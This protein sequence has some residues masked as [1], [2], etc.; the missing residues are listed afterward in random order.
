MVQYIVLVVIMITRLF[1][2]L[3]PLI[4]F[5]YVYFIFNFQ[6]IYK[7][8]NNRNYNLHTNLGITNNN[9]NSALLRSHFPN[10]QTVTHAASNHHAN[11]IPA[12]NWRRHFFGG[13][14]SPPP[15]PS[16]SQTTIHSLSSKFSHFTQNSE[17]KASIIPLRFLRS[18]QC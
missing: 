5:M 1:F 13:G 15:S 6:H 8:V 16:P 18:S 17:T 11:A 10:A 12:G 9:A 14:G 4:D 2:S 7:Q 3:Y